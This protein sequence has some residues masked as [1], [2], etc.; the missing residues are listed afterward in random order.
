M[1]T[2]LI[3]AEAYRQSTGGLPDLHRATTAAAIGFIVDHKTLDRLWSARR[4]AESYSDVIVPSGE[5]R[6]R[7]GMIVRPASAPQSSA[8]AA[9]C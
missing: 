6:R 2:I 4:P 9:R 7:G 1:V 5:G 3:S 8:H